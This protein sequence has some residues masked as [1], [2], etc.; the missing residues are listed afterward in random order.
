MNKTVEENNM[1]TGSTKIVRLIGVDSRLSMDH[2]ISVNVCLYRMNA[3]NNAIIV[4]IIQMKFLAI[5]NKLN[6]RCIMIYYNWLNF[7]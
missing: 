7:I 2:S 4:K 1:P 5:E 6:G 3:V